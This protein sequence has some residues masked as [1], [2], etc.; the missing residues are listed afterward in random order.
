MWRAAT[1]QPNHR[2][3]QVERHALPLRPGRWDG[4]D[5][6]YLGRKRGRHATVLAASDPGPLSRAPRLLPVQRGLCEDDGGVPAGLPALRASRQGGCGRE[7]IARFQAEHLGAG[8][9]GR[10]KQRRCQLGCL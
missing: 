5:A 2:Y 3:I 4:L 7:D 9:R 1:N 6:G 10:K 8:T